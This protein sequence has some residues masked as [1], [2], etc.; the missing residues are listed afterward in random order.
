MAESSDIVFYRYSP[1][2]MSEDILRKLFV[3]REKLLESLVTEIE[4]ASK[5]GTPRFYLMVGPRGIGKSHF[6][7]LLYYE[8][9]NKVTSLIPIKLAEEEYSIY[10]ASDFFLRILE[11]NSVDVS[12][13]LS[14]DNENEILYASLE[15]LKQISKQDRK[16][17][18]IFIENLHELFKQLNKE[19]LHKLRSTFQK[20]DIFSVVATAPLIFPFI[21]E[22]EEPF[23]NFFRIQHLKEF[24]INEIKELMIKIA[25]T[26]N[27]S[28]FLDNFEQYEE[29]IHGIIHL[30]GGS[31]RLA[32]LF[33]ELIT[34][35]EIKDIE[36]S[37]FKIIDEHTPFYQEVFQLLTPQ[38][39]RIF[40]IL[41]SFGEPVTPKQISQKARMNL[42]IVNT[43]MRRLETNGYV[44][45]RPMGRHTKYEVRERLFRLWR[46]MRQPFGRKRVSILLDF[47][48]LWYT[49]DEKKELFKTTF[50]FLEAGDRS[51]IKDLCYYAEIQ[52]PD[53][54][55][56]ALLK[57]TPKL[58]EIGENEDARYEI[59]KLKEHA[60]KYKGAGLD[61]EISRFELQLLFSEHK[62]EEVIEAIDKSI[63]VNP[64]DAVALMDKG[65]ALVNSRK[66]EEALE[67]FNKVLEIDPV[68]YY[69]LAIKGN[70]LANIEKYEE[71]LEVLNK[72]LEIDPNND[73]TLLTSK[74]NALVNI[75]EYEEAIG[76]FDKSLEI[77][78]ND[79]FALTGK[80]VAL[81]SIGEDDK[82]I[83]VFDKAIE[84]NP[85]NYRAF[86]NKGVSL[87]HLEKFEEALEMTNM[88]LEINPDDNSILAN[89]GFVLGNLEKYEEAIDVFDKSLEIDPDDNLTL[90]NKGVVLL[91]IGKYEDALDL[92]NKAIKINPNYV[93][94]LINKGV[95]LGNLEKHEE[96][97]EVFD[98]V[99]KINPN[100]EFAIENKAFAL[101]NLKRHTEVLEVARKMVD[102]ATD[103]HS[104]INASLIV[105]E[106]YIALNRKFEAAFEIEKIESKMID[107]DPDLIEGF[108]N[109]CLNLAQD[110][111]KNN[112]R[113][114]ASKFIKIA[115]KNSFKLKNAAVKKLTMGFLKSA[116]D[117]GILSV[118]KAAVEEIIDQQKDEFEQLIRPITKAIEIVETKDLK[119]YY[120]LQIE[121]REIVADVVKRITRSDEL[122]P[123]EIKMK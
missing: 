5:N 7:T 107:Q 67:V 19:E 104:K 63:K 47:L 13:V 113:G 81:V 80:G 122:I 1:E 48:Q 102:V 41:I 24:S 114:S 37:L 111:L 100:Y 116:A 44:I 2:N 109:I 101:S 64:N 121:E 17:F 106:A 38:Q 11:E 40:D 88:A 31:P 84:I 25:K 74:G 123:D 86:A 70:A 14:L 98:K 36:K 95:L 22:H 56:E 43:Q 26:E 53:F 57:L 62:Y 118:I 94:T 66:Y 72:A 8:I 46:E 49:P 10:R 89:K 54:K 92:F 79:N 97:L 96:A 39:R 78:P 55:A 75:G 34:R 18:I 20:Y 110:E 83:E 108:M 16:T 93:F 90:T 51:V 60:A 35:G 76:V 115:F 45:S 30:T 105:I 103:K 82:A 3:S 52:P 32:F 112:N 68:N 33:Y 69:A 85:I 12:D 42:P 77:D 29:K 50:K 21:S 119:K 27:N 61:D 59:N 73:F 9:E 23:Y 28:E 15:K 71:A 91:H 58:L 99:L 65:V 120:D 4:D 117:T 6:L 87:G